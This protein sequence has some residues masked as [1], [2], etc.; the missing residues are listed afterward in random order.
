[1]ASPG[2]KFVG[3]P[4]DDL[5]CLLCLAKVAIDPLQHEK[6]GKLFCTKCIEEHGK[7][8]PCP[9]CKES[10][11]YYVDNRSKWPLRRWD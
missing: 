2:Y 11:L 5:K 4:D 7:Q 1:M 6:C 10:G 3:E 8:E 9:N